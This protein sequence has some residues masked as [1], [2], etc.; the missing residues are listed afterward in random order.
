VK[1]RI[2]RFCERLLRGTILA[3]VFSG[4]FG[5]TAGWVLVNDYTIHEP[6]Q[7][8]DRP[9]MVTR[10]PQRLN[11]KLYGL[12]AVESV[13]WS[14]GHSAVEL[15]VDNDGNL[16]SDDPEDKREEG[17]ASK[18]SISGRGAFDDTITVFTIADGAVAR[19]EALHTVRITPLPTG[20]VGGKHKATT[21]DG[22]GFS[23]MSSRKVPDLGLMEGE[24]GRL[25][26]DDGKNEPEKKPETLNAELYIDEDQFNAMFV[27]IR[28]G[29]ANIETVH[30]GIAAELFEGEMQ[31]SLSEWWMPRE[32]GMLK[33]EDWVTTRA[34]L[35]SL[36]VSFGGRLPVTPVDSDDLDEPQPE[37]P[38]TP[39]MPTSPVHDAEAKALLKRLYARGGWILAA[40]VILIVVTLVK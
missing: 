18:R 23:G 25:W 11:V 19:F 34:R 27:A 40:L 35:D 29:V 9:F 12:R 17:F 3:K 6:R 28:D 20:M 1:S 15:T 22:V 5:D 31:A 8:K 39:P 4:E 14:G 7:L 37:T 38:Q 10:V 13:E 32:Y 16:A 21:M 36:H 2:V 24:P 33:K 26:L 30:V